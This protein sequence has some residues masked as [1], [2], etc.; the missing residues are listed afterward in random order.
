MYDLPVDELKKLNGMISTPELR[1]GAKI[2]VPALATKTDP[3]SRK[4][5]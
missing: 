5:S 2:K 1:T 3:S 4:N